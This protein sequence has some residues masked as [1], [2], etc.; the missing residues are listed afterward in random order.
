[1]NRFTAMTVVLALAFSAQA[2]KKDEPKKE[3]KDKSAKVDAKPAKEKPKKRPRVAPLAPD[4]PRTK[5]GDFPV[6]AELEEEADRTVAIE[7]LEA[8]LDRLEAEIIGLPK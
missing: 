4:E 1:M 3:E 6:S 8:E 5:L 2:C 7:N